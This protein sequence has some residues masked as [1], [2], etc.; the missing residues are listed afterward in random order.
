MISLSALIK[1]DLNLDLCPGC[2]ASQAFEKSVEST[3]PNNALKL[4]VIR[5]SS[6]Y[7][8]NNHICYLPLTVLKLHIIVNGGSYVIHL[9][10]GFNLRSSVFYRNIVV[11]NFCT[12]NIQSVQ[13]IITNN[14]GKK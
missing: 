4:S 1:I 14:C 8:V 11:S 13:R 7:I 6:G 2:S 9:C 3:L 5:F 12:V 10:H